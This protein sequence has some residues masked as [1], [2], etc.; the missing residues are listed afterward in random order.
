[1]AAE[2]ERVV[3]ATLGTAGGAA[4]APQPA[5]EMVPTMATAP[6]Q[7]SATNLLS[8][9]DRA[10][11]SV[12]GELLF[13]I[14]EIGAAFAG[15]NMLR[16]WQASPCKALCGVT[17]SNGVCLPMTIAGKIVE[18]QSLSGSAAGTVD[19]GEGADKLELTEPIPLPELR[20]HK[21][22]FMKLA[23]QN[24][25]SN[26][27]SSDAAVRMFVSYLQNQLE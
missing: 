23:T 27:K 6:P 10:A 3:A 12:I 19:F 15:A 24:A 7:H 20:R 13:W 18:A 25:F 4:G 1:M 9:I 11:Q 14:Y 8:D 26:L 2:L 5:R 22:S 16:A 21:R 17:E